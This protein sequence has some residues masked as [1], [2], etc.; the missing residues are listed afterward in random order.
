[1][2]KV[3]V[4]LLVAS[5]VFAISSCSKS[6]SSP[7]TTARVNFVNGCAGTSAL[8]L[9]VNGTAIPN[10][11][12]LTYLKA[13]GY[14][15][16]TA[17]SDS[18]NVLVSSIAQSLV[19]TPIEQTTANTSYSIFAGGLSTKGSVI[20]TTDDLTTPASGDA[21]VRVVNAC[22]D[23]N[24]L[25][26]TA[27]MGSSAAVALASNLGYAS[28]SAFST[29]TAGTYKVVVLQPSNPVSA[30]DTNNVQ[31]SAGKI[32]TVMFSGNSAGGYSLSVFTNN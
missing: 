12:T 5:S 17:G 20:F 3:I 14:Q 32:Y 4:S 22:A 1:M 7:S 31:F 2:K 25:E 19:S 18:F 30:I 13:S 6:S 11:S 24:A 29:I 15:N 9:T 27:T 23:T 8:G 21:K 26:G 10:A 16:F 28:A